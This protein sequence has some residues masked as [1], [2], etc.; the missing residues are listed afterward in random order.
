VVPAEETR[1]VSL[2][3][4][5][6]RLTLERFL[7]KAQ[8]RSVKVIGWKSK[9]SPFVVAGVFPIEV[10]HISLQEGGE[11]VLFVKHLGPEQADHPDKQH[12]DREPRIYEELLGGDSLPVPRY[13][14]S[15]WNEVTK[16]LEFFLEYIGDWSLKYQDLEHWFPAAR[17]LAQ[18][19]AHFAGRTTQLL[20]R[21]Y[22]LRLDALYFHQWAER[23][24]AVVAEQA[25]ELA[26]Q[27]AKVVNNYGRV[28]DILARQPLTLV[29]NDLAP[30]NVL[31]D[32]SHHPA[33]ICFV[34]WEMAGVGCGLLDLVHL[35]YGLDPA[36]DQAMRMA[37]CAEL[38]GTNLLPSNPTELSRLFAACEIHHTLYRLASSKAWRLP[39]DRVGQ[40]VTEAYNLA[41]HF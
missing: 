7:S 13:Y 6:L 36:S 32:R 25:S 21:D 40:W 4:D 33:R 38:A 18:F 12:R 8:M 15:R 17:C 31:A 24:L 19:H 28:A 26:D 22:L 20:A 16:R 2:E 9:P 5:S 30:K 35:K 23:G 41:R 10:L 11:V 29:H 27:L 3:E 1:L 39:L 14:G 34:D 37:Y